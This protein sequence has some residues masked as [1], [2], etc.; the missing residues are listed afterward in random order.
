MLQDIILGWVRTLIA[1]GAGSLVAKGYID[2]DQSNELIGAAVTIVPIALSALDK[3]VARQRTAQAV[4]A[5]AVKGASSG[6]ATASQ[7][8]T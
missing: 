3:I 6:A 5:Q 4:V 8:L 1:V 7:S 2:H